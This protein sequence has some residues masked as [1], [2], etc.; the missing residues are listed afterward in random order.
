MTIQKIKNPNPDC[1]QEDCKFVQGA[2]FVTLAYYQPVYDKAGNL[3]TTEGNT[4]S[5]SV[6]C[7]TCGGHWTYIRAHGVTTYTARWDNG[8]K[9][10]D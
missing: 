7:L 8:P 2:E 10:T 3:I 9:D 4:A 5:G 6:N 1:A